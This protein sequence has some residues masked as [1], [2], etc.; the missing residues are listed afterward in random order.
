MTKKKNSELAALLDDFE[1]LFSF[2]TSAECT[3]E[4]AF[5]LLRM[6]KAGKRRPSA[7][8]R[9]YSNYS[10]RRKAREREELRLLTKGV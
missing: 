4:K 1:K 9:I 2:L 3:E 5:E 8:N 6:E 7:L 10:V